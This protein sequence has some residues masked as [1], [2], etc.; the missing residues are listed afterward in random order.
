MGSDKTAIRGGYAIFHD[1]AWN[2]GGQGLWQNPPYDAELDPDNYPNVLLTPSFLS[3]GLCNPFGSTQC[4]LSY[5]FQQ[6][7]P[8][9]AACPP[10][11]IL[12]SP[13]NPS[14]YTGTIQSENR[15][16]KQGMIQQFN[17]NIER[18]LPANVV[19]TLGYAGARSS[20][21]L[22]GQLNENISS[23]SACGVV[24]VTLSA[25]VFRHSL[26]PPL[27]RSSPVITATERHVMT[28]RR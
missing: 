21:I 26:M 7:T 5:G 19:L 27:F 17:L 12:T 9:N 8:S 20:R 22:V 28:L 24:P 2:Q 18:Q 11:G 4:G 25:A 3:T 1:S 6:A 16:F 15:N 13:V 23:P 10:A 14:C